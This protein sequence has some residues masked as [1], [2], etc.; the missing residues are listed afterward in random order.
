M[1]DATGLR[2][3][4]RE[5][6]YAPVPVD[7]S[8]ND[9]QTAIDQY[10]DFLELDDRCHEATRF[11]LGKRGDGD[12]G[13]FRREAGSVNGRGQVQDNKDI[14]HFGS[15]SRQVVEARLDGRL[16]TAMRTF[17]DSAESLYWTAERSKRGAV[18]QLDVC[19]NGLLSVMQT[20]TGMLNDVLRFIA[21]YP[22][23]GT[24]AR[25]HFDRSAMTVALGESHGGLRMTPGQNH[26][27]R[28]VNRDYIQQLQDA[29][30]PVEHRNGEAKF[31]LGAGWNRLSAEHRAGNE[32]LPLAWH[33]V[34]SSKLPPSGKV[35]RWAIVLFAN[36][37][38]GY[39]GYEAPSPTE[40]R[41]Y[42]GMPAK[43]SLV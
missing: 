6:G 25:A 17:L 40:T 22:N 4:L 21:Y 36:P 14:F 1:S 39:Q 43:G 26:R 2:D 42:K 15:M 30:Q 9:M 13:Q 41:P 28:E 19:K 31:F 35:A 20:E 34:V 12:Y 8:K 5:Y 16:P 27:M 33:D 11:L 38:W 29:L 37:H 24:L 7:V 23:D 3:N 18:E 10:M 32:E